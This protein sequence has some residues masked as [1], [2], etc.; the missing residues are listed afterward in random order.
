[1]TDLS[2]NEPP[3]VEFDETGIAAWLSGVREF[4]IRW[5]DI[6]T[7]EIDVVDYC[8]TD[9]EAFW[10]IDGSQ[11]TPGA[12]AFY[13]PVELI[14]G[15]DELTARLRSLAGFDHEAFKRA[16]IAEGR[17]EAGRFLCWRSK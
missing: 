10:L 13:A 9:A 1:M 2:L 6:C 4:Y 15:G 3:R 8:D 17:G 14:V 5:S 11:S 12:P 7:V 16:R